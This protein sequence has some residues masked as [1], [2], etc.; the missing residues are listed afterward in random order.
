MTTTQ[1]TMVAALAAMEDAVQR[2]AAAYAQYQVAYQQTTRELYAA[3]GP[4][5][6]ADVAHAIG[7]ERVDKALAMRLTALGLE[8]ILSYAPALGPAGPDWIQPLT[9][10]IQKRVP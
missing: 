9:A 8:Q 7:V 5:R 3:P 1:D 10:Q 6:L 2:L 4:E